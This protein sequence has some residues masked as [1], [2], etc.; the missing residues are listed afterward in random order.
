MTSLETLYVR[1]AAN[2]HNFLLVTHMTW[3]DKR[4]GRYGILKSAFSSRQILD[5]LDIQV[6]GQVFGPQDG[7]NMLGFEYKF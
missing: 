4:F 5:R 1:N 6:L 3:F 7:W 2:E